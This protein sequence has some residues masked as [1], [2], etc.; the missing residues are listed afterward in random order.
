MTINK[1]F[2]FLCAHEPVRAEEEQSDVSKHF[3][4]TTNASRQRYAL[5][6]HERI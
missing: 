5:P 1:S 6:Q 2:V 4:H 3:A